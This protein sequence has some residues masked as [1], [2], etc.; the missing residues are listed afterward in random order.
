[1]NPADLCSQKQVFLGLHPDMYA[2]RSPYF[3]M[4]GLAPNPVIGLEAREEGRQI[5]GSRALKLIH[6]S[7]ELWLAVEFFSTER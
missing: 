3:L 7:E 2:N 4:V 6:R 1:M 5:F